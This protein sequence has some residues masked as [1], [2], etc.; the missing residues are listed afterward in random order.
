LTT[1]SYWVSRYISKNCSDSW[2]TIDMWWAGTFPYYQN[3]LAFYAR[4]IGLNG[5]QE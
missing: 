1:S 4:F 5:V 2:H 3:G